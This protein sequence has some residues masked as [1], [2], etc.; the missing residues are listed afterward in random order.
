MRRVFL[1]KRDALTELMM[2][3]VHFGLHDFRR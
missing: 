1:E 3:A 2:I